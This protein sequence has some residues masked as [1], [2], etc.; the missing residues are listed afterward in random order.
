VPGEEA[1]EAEAAPSA[2]APVLP[3]LGGT[4]FLDTKKQKEL[5]AKMATQQQ[6]EQAAGAPAA[7]PAAPP[8]PSAMGVL[9]VLAGRADQSEY[10]LEAQTCLIGKSDTATVRL[11]GWFKPKVAAAIARKGGSYVITPLSG[12][13]L[14]NNQPLQDRYELKNGDILQVSGLTL[15]FRLKG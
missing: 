11:K 2:E 14:V 8:T 9:R 1:V 4:V 6:A 3:E 12:K 5:L 15:E 13:T 7:A 10:S